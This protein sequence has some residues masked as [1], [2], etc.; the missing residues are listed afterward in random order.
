MDN[1]WRCSQ[2]KKLLGI[3]RDG[4]LHLKFARGPDYL[5]GFPATGACRNC[6]TLNELREAP[7]IAGP[8]IA[9]R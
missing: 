4:R 8:F 2:C 6:K 7:A 5:V 9:A 1:Q 3:I